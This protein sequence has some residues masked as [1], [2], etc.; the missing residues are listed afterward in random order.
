MSPFL[1][2]FRIISILPSLLGLFF[3]LASFLRTRENDANNVWNAGGRGESKEMNGCACFFYSDC[4]R[5]RG[6]RVGR[7]G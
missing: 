2:P 3:L 6:Q 5:D 7:L 1:C 4:L